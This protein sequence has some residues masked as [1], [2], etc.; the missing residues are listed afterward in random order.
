MAAWNAFAK[1][2]TNKEGTAKTASRIKEILRKIRFSKPEPEKAATNA[3]RQNEPNQALLDAAYLGETAEIQSLLNAG[4]DIDAKSGSGNT[5]LTLAAR[6]NQAEACALL[7]EKGADVNAADNY[8]RTAL[9]Y[10]AIWGH[11]KVCRLLVWHGADTGIREIQ[12][13]HTARMVAADVGRTKVEAYLS[14]MERLQK[15]FGKQEFRAFISA[16]NLCISA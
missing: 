11:L 1:R 6:Q 13:N 16:F 8:G 3:A 14:R 10:A 7:L 12:K 2:V 4:A 5:P 9:I 15:L